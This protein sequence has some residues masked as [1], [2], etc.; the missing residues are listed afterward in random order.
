M[1]KMIA[2][3]LVLLFIVFGCATEKRRNAIHDTLRLY[4]KTLRWGAYRE[5]Q[6]LKLEV[7]KPLPEGLNEIK[8]TSYEIVSQSVTEDAD[9]LEQ[10]VEIKFYHEQ[11]GMIKTL[12]DRQTWVYDDKLDG[13]FLE[14]ELPDFMSA[15]Q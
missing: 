3:L 15:I 2:G 4:E 10:T 1:V 9:Q 5:A 6:T 14:S 7:R 13:W 8:V 12:M 11:Q